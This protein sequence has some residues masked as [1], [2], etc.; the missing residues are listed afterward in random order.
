MLKLF[1][2]RERFRLTSSHFVT[3]LL[4]I[5]DAGNRVLHRHLPPPSSRRGP[6]RQ[7]QAIMTAYF[8]PYRYL[9]FYDLPIRIRDFAVAVV[10]GNYILTYGDAGEPVFNDVTVIDFD[11]RHITLT[12]G[13]SFEGVM[14]KALIVEIKRKYAERIMDAMDELRDEWDR[15]DTSWQA[16]GQRRFVQPAVA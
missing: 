6:F 5:P 10:E 1:T 13:D 16:A 3:Y 12:E 9:E 8:V 15:H 2:G 7:G 4:A 14:L 11:G